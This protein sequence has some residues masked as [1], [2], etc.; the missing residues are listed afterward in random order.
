M[1][2]PAGPLPRPRER[3]NPLRSEEGEGHRRP[4]RSGATSVALAA[5][6]LVATCLVAASLG[7]VAIPIDAQLGIVAARVGVPVDAGWPATWETILLEIRLPRIVLGA[8][9]GCGL[10]VA[11]ATYQ[12]LFRNPLADPYLL[13]VAAGAGLGAVIAFILP[14]PPA[15]Y[16]VGVVQVLAFVGAFGAVGTVFSLARVGRTVPTTTLLLAG[17]ALGSL[18]SAT[19]AYLMYQFGDR[20]IVIYAWLI[21]GFNVA[22]WNQ[23]WLIA[24]GVLVSALVI[25]L[26]GRMLNVLQLGEEGA[27]A[28]GM[29]VEPTKLLLVSA[30]TLATASAVS[31]AGLI[32]FVGLIVPHVVRLLVGPDYRRLVPMAAIVGAAFLV[33]ADAAA[34][35]L[36]GP[37]E[38][39]VGVVTAAC[40]APFFLWL[41]RRQ[42]RDLF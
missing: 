9:V 32:G 26:C 25:G 13:G 16:G 14:F 8:L 42:K 12:G 4:L 39:P 38:I 3:G 1:A 18:L 10:A 20:L 29:P 17:V 6:A 5:L 28:L 37:T 33:A 21:G 24:P 22:T 40:G 34:R 36:P 41:L 23:V 27:A 7:K 11:G 2:S 15:L 35:S 19:T 31:A 30:A